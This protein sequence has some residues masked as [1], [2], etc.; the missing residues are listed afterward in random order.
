MKC[1]A[2]A[3][4]VLAAGSDDHDGISIDW[5]PNYTEAL[6]LAREQDKP[7]L[8]VVDNPL[9]PKFRTEHARR[10][11]D[12]MQSKL[13]GDYGRCHVDVTT[14][15]GK[16]VARIFGVSRFPF[17]AIIDASTSRVLYRNTGKMSMAE[18]VARLAQFGDGEHASQLPA[19]RSNRVSRP[20]SYAMPSRNRS[21]GFCYT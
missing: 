14:D 3:L 16:Q 5:A 9:E 8:L 20:P 21:R 2:L 1:I 4:L 19:T 15:H 6:K 17:V 10:S 13:L 18:W 11:P 7:L 12:A